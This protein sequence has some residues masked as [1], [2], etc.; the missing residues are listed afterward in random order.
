MDSYY[1]L[2][3]HGRQITTNSAEAQLWFDRGLVWC[4]GYNHEEA[5]AC[6][7]R[8]L[9]HDPGCAMAHWGVAY[10]IGPNYNKPWEAFDDEDKRMSL[11]RALAAGAAARTHAAGATAGEQALIGALQ[12]RYPESAETDDFGPGTTPMRTQ[13]ARSMRRIAT[14]STSAR[15]SPRRS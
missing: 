14:T 4:Y 8:A 2:G 1:D 5:V 11:G 9:K 6:F 10:A 7:E 3:S 15:C 13:C 12:H